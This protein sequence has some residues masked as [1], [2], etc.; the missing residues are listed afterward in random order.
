VRN[1]LRDVVWPARFEVLGREPYFVV[2]GAH[3]VDS[4]RSLARTLQQYF[5]NTVPW[6]VLAILTDKDAPAILKQLLPL[7]R[8][9]FFARSAHPRAADPYQLQEEGAR[10]PVPT[11]V[12][13]DI[14]AAT[15][16]AIAQADADG[17][18]V[19]A[20]SFTTAGE[21]REAWLRLHGCPLPPLDPR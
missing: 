20:G 11:E 13:E 17:L 18:V 19:A 15:S 1:G 5:P 4:A 2:D 6:F 16:R 14:G 9:A 10:Y 7:A 3:N 21:A 8:G 12:I